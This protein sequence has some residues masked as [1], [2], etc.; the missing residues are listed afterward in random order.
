VLAD[1]PTG[2]LDPENKQRVLDILR[3]YADEHAAT[4]LSVTHDHALLDRFDRVVDFDSLLGN[5]VETVNAL[6]PEC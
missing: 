4:L 2:N 3:Q 5:D 6:G 1:E